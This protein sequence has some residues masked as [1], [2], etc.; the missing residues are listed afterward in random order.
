MA[1]PPG[2]TSPDGHTAGHAWAAAQAGPRRHVKI[3]PAH[4]T[5]AADAGHRGAHLARPVSGG[6]ER[7]DNFGLF[8]RVREALEAGLL[9]LKVLVEA[10][11][12]VAHRP[13]R[14][15]AGQRGAGGQLVNIELSY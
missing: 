4:T 14:H 6:G 10:G 2:A 13:A 12:P 8:V 3:C 9:A 15:Q 7:F 1:G 5:S 11:G